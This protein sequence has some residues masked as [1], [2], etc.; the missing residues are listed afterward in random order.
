M[1]GF[2]KKLENDNWDKKV[3]SIST[4]IINRLPENRSDDELL[5]IIEEIEEA[6]SILLKT[7]DANTFFSNL[8]KTIQEPKDGNG[9]FLGTIQHKG[10]MEKCIH[11]DLKRYVALL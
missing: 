7:S 9:I 2:S 11:W 1:F 4:F 6:K 8:K 3:K 10:L 5:D